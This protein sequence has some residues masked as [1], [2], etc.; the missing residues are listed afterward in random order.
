MTKRFRM[1][2]I[3]IANTV[4]RLS[5]IKTQVPTV[6]SR[7]FLNVFMLWANGKNTVVNHGSFHRDLATTN[8]K[9]D[10]I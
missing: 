3:C 7:F 4:V 2:I 1:F 10:G 6:S 9:H 5:K 8:Q